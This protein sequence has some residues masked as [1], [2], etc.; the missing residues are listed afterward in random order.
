MQKPRGKGMKHPEKGLRVKEA[1]G[2]IL[3]GKKAEK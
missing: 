3:G 2:N 1:I